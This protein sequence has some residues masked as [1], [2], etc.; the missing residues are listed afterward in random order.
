MLDALK[1]QVGG[2]HYQ[3]ME[4]QPAEYI[5]ANDL[6]HYEAAAIEYISRWKIKGGVASLEKAR[7]CLQILIDY[8]RQQNARTPDIGHQA[9]VDA[10]RAAEQEAKLD[11]S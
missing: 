8:Q 3:S 10:A 2:D 9:T 5:L 6:G 11:A 1:K 4:I 7:Q